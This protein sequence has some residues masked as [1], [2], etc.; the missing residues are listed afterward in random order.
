MR[1]SGMKMENGT[2]CGNEGLASKRRRLYSGRAMR[3][4]AFALFALALAP[5]EPQNAVVLTRVV[6][7]EHPGLVLSNDRL[8]V[9][10]LEQGGAFASLAL[11]D[12]PDRLNPLWDP[13]RMTREAGQKR[14]AGT[15][16]G[17]FVCVDGFGP[18]SPEE[19][20]AGLPGHGEAHRQAWKLVSSTREGGVVTAAFS[21]ELPLTQE[22]FSRT[23]RIRDGEQVVYVASELENLLAF[24]RPVCWA[25][26][27]TI[28]APFL[29]PE[30]TVVDL[31]ARRSRTRRHDKDP[32]PLS[33]R[34]AYLQEFTC[35][36]APLAAGGLVDLRA[37]PPNPNSLDHTTCLLDPERP[38]A[39]VTA[40]H[41]EKRLLVGWL[42][43]REEFPWLQS[44]ENYT[45]NLKMARGLEFSTQPFDVPRR[46]VID[47]G[48]MFDAP[49]YR[50]L[51]ARSRI[52]SSFLIFYTRVPD[53]FRRVDDVR[54]EQG[55]LQIEDRGSEKR[56]EL[57]VALSLHGT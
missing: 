19:Q 20:A 42:F 3:A 52:R 55:K 23:V 43:K 5:A 29:E 21:A 8:E 31:P 13:A 17:H 6:F 56:V 49:V 28:G 36:I 22:R 38:L 11:R 37:A 24:D 34:L 33:H 15:G 40:L 57:E 30:K 50:W 54:L 35:P 1:L 4:F 26:H 25:E 39:F 27:A 12:D 45:P 7:E 46:E 10:I 47:M 9:T 2:D 32:G 18:V 53:G 41:L 48:R 51:P 14:P 16:V 44:W